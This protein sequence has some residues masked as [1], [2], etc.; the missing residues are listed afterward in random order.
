MTLLE[1][2]RSWLDELLDVLDFPTPGLYVPKLQKIL[3]GIKDDDTI[4]G[5]DGEL[6]RIE[7]LYE[8]EALRLDPR[9]CYSDFLIRLEDRIAEKIDQFEE[10]KGN[11]EEI[12][13]TAHIYAEAYRLRRDEIVE[14]IEVEGQFR[15]KFWIALILTPILGQILA[16]LINLILKAIIEANLGGLIMP[17]LALPL[18]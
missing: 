5:Q 17:P 16:S 15:P 1:K 10:L 7:P 14:R 18:P 6:D 9:F 12:K 8:A 3:D 11:K 4:F 13:E 2:E